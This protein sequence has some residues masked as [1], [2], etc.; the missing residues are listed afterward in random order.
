[1]RRRTEGLSKQRFFLHAPRVLPVAVTLAL[2][3]ATAPVVASQSGP[4]QL[5]LEEMDNITAGVASGHP[6]SAS[7]GAIVGNDSSATLNSTGHVELLEGAQANARAMNLVTGAESTIA[8]GINVFDGRAETTADIMDG[9]HFNV[10]QINDIVQEQ[11]RV[12]SVPSYERIEANI[13]RV[14][15]D[16]GS[17]FES[18][19]LASSENITNVETHS[20][21]RSNESS[22]RVNAKSTVLGQEIQAGRGLSGAGDLGVHFDAGE[23]TF[24]SGGG[25]SLPGDVSFEGEVRVNLRLPEM[26]VEFEGAGCAVQNGSC[27]AEGRFEEEIMDMVDRSTAQSQESSEVSE[28]SWDTA[29]DERI[30]A[31]FVL[32]DA[33]A[34]YIVVDSSDLTVESSYLVVLAG[35]AQADVRAMNVVNAAGSAVANGVNVA[36]QRSGALNAGGGQSLNLTQTNVISHSR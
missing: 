7:G 4:S 30:R 25:V 36:T 9:A 27:Q 10:A 29:L 23:F 24:E 26:T 12:A 20:F 34:E 22:G 33:Q 13:D 18:S 6:L 8:N 14:T 5:N 19:E 15:S 16:S 17:S 11:R 3:G 28:R 1:M 35:N 2:V 21:A 32:R 31:P